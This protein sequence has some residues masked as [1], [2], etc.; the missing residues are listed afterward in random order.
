MP[1]TGVSLP[2]SCGDTHSCGSVC[3]SAITAPA[4]P[5]P[6]SSSATPTHFESLLR[7]SV[8]SARMP[9]SLPTWPTSR[10]QVRHH[11]DSKLRRV[12]EKELERDGALRHFLVPSATVYKTEGFAQRDFSEAPK[13]TQPLVDCTT[14]IGYDTQLFCCVRASPKVSGEVCAWLCYFLPAEE[15]SNQNMYSCHLHSPLGRNTQGTGVQDRLMGIIFPVCLLV[16][17]PHT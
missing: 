12:K 15:H 1:Q 13:F 17:V 6:T 8:G 7:T 16:F 3:W 11:Q 2:A 10:K 14:V 4:A 5:S 9:P